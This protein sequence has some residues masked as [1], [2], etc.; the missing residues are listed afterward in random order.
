MYISYFSFETYRPEAVTDIKFSILIL[1]LLQNWPFIGLCSILPFP[2]G[3][4]IARGS[5]LVARTS[6]HSKRVERNHCFMEIGR[7]EIVQ[8]IS[9]TV[10]LCVVV[11]LG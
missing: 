3:I 5:E 4:T 7:L 1:V 8:S 6:M 9:A 10:Y 11:V 2:H